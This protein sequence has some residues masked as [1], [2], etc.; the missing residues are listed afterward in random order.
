MIP[1]VFFAANLSNQICQV[2]FKLVVG[3][4]ADQ[5]TKSKRS[6]FE[7]YLRIFWFFSYKIKF[8]KLNSS[9]WREI[10]PIMLQNQKGA[11]LR[12]IWECFL[13]FFLTKSN[14]T[15]YAQVG[16]EK[17]D[18]SYYKIKKEIKIKHCQRHNGPRNWLRDLELIHQPHG[19]ICISCKIG[20]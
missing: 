10:W 2:K 8:D 13:I 14:L 15:S 19:S 1:F 17:F 16:G 7:K 18:R 6:L 4:L 11:C 3:N 20:H 12:N 5:M 9:C